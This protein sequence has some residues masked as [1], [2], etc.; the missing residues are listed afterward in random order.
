MTAEVLVIG[1]H[2]D[3]HVARCAAVLGA[4]G[5]TCEVLWLGLARQRYRIHGDL[6]SMELG[7]DGRRYPLADYRHVLCLP[8]A[9]NRPSMVDT[10]GDEFGE[11]EWNAL[12]RSVLV[13]SAAHSPAAWLIH[14]DA[15]LLQDRKI[16]LLQCA[17]RACPEL[18]IPPTVITNEL[19]DADVALLGDRIVVKPINAW[20]EVSP[21]RYFNTTLL[22]DAA[23]AKIRQVG[24][25]DTPTIFQRFL[26]HSIEY[27]CYC[28]HNAVLTVRLQVAPGSADSRLPGASQ[29]ATV[30][31]DEQDFAPALRE[32]TRSLRVHYCCFDMV[33]DGSGR[34]WLTDINPTGSWRY[35]ENQFDCDLTSWIL[36][37][38]LGRSTDG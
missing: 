11:R 24:P 36:A 8:M 29:G 37:T 28:V 12:L 3:Q 32:I 18:A 5:R 4:A 35:L 2:D 14:P 22:T 1:R 30:T 27:R 26:P 20:Q 9:V 17:A 21:G 7:L 31:T 23:L 6:A 13:R 34:S 25:L 15:D 16:A 38:W 19:L 33:M 10:D